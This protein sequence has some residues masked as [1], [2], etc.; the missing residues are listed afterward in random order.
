MMRMA[1]D[2]LVVGEEQLLQGLRQFQFEFGR[3]VADVEQESPAA[4]L[5]SLDEAVKQSPPDYRP[6]LEEALQCY[7]H[8]LYRAT[9]LMVWTA[10]MQHLYSAASSH[11]GGVAAI[12]KANKARFGNTKRYR[13]IRKQDDF[14]YMGERDFIQL[15]EDAGMYNRNARGQLHDRLKLRNLCGHPTQYNPGREETVIFTESLLLNVLS[16]SWLNW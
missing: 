16:G 4:A 9:I 12:Q 6:Y 7:R 13:E 10:A 11:R 15:G 3:E 2:E 1:T 14:L 8:G 5:E